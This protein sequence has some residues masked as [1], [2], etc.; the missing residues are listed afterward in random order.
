MIR[1][2]VPA[3]FVPL[4]E[5]RLYLRVTWVLLLLLALFPVLAPLLDLVGVARSGLPADHGAAFTALSGSSWEAARAAQPGIARFIGVLEQGYALHE[6]VFGVLFL[7]IVAIPFRRGER[8]SWF[9]CWAV[10]IADL[11]YTLTL[12][13]H[14]PTLF[15]QSLIADLALPALLLLQIRRFFPGRL[16]VGVS[17]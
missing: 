3:A 15:R 14:D 10:L 16:I 11:G 6:V 4:S 1:E 5:E 2:K 8:W 12:A 13:R 9:T 7:V 17:R